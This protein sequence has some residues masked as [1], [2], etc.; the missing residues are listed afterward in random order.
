MSRPY[1]RKADRGTQYAEA[2][3]HAHQVGYAHCS[4]AEAMAGFC[5]NLPILVGAVSPRLVWEGAMAYGLQAQDLMKIAHDL[6][7]RWLDALQFDPP[8]MTLKEKP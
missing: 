1:I 2:L 5:E 7:Y 6:D 4:E 8:S 3:I